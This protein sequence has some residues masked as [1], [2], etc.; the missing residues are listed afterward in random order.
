MFAGGVGET[1][2]LPGKVETELEIGVEDVF[3]M[4]RG[5]DCEEKEIGI[6]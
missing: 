3:R 1:F 5:I 4:G 6:P 2:Y